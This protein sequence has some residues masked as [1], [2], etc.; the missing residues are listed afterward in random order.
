[1]DKSRKTPATKGGANGRAT[2][3]G[4]SY[5]PAAHLSR[6]IVSS[7][8]CDIDY[9]L[10]VVLVRRASGPTREDSNP[11]PDRGTF[12]LP[13]GKP[14]SRTIVPKEHAVAVQEAL[15]TT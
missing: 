1:M 13:N 6:F 7:L 2:D 11:D 10:A 9:L 5:T 15:G 14:A 3:E 4:H 8:K 12:P